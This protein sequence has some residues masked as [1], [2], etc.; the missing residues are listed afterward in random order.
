MGE[1]DA[2]ELA[3]CNSKGE[4]Q[5]RK[6]CSDSPR[7]SVEERASE[8]DTHACEGQRERTR[9]CRQRGTWWD[10]NTLSRSLRGSITLSNSV[11]W[12]QL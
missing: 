6:S 11:T 12:I 9:C 2:A 4:R 10:L 8:C 7:Y 5:A 3:P 1:V